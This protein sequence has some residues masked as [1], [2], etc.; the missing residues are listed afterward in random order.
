M[1]AL[2][3]RD[4]V[5]LGARGARLRPAAQAERAVARAWSTGWRARVLSAGVALGLVWIAGAVALQAPAV[6]RPARRHPA[7][8]HPARA[9]RHAAALG[10]D[11]QRAGALRP[12]PA[13]RRAAGRRAGAAGGDRARPRRAARGARRGQDPGDRVRAR[14]SRA[15]A[16]SPRR[17]R[18]DQRPRRRRPG[19]HDGPA[20]RHRARGSRRARSSSTPTTTS[21]SC[22]WP[23]SAAAA[24]P[25]ASE[26]RSG[27]SGAIL[28]FPRERPVRR[29]RRARGRDPR[30]AHAGRLRARARPARDRHAARHGAPGQ[31]RRPARRRARARGGDR[32][33]GHARRH[34]AAATG[35]PTPSS[36]AICARPATARCPPGRAPAE[37]PCPVDVQ[38]PRHR[39]E[40]VRGPGPRSRPARPL[41][42]A[43]GAGRRPRWLEGP[44]HVITWAVG[45]LVQLAEPDEYDDKFKKWR[46]ADL[47]IV[48][49][50]LQARRPRRALRE[51]DDG[52]PRPAARATT[53]TSSST[54]ATPGARAS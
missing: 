32:L 48:P 2:H 40:A 25:I 24:L 30:G 8:E 15:R 47:P 27:A 26:P 34:A 23:G 50:T 46:M 12:L 16:G 5:R 49:R 36:S 7:L 41:R 51:A 22:A 4:A 1:G 28:G 6:A 29:P 3:R 17:R 53:S 38:D 45:H 10:A 44:E 14:A 52:R 21:R 9:Q 11:P 20:R 39:R 18:R 43:H 42:E 35:C 54:P 33:R 37:L 19:R 31:L 13:H